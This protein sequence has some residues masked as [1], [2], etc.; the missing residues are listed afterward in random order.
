MMKILI[1]EQENLATDLYYPMLRQMGYKPCLPVTSAMEAFKFLQRTPVDLV[2]L[3]LTVA[4]YRGALDVAAYIHQHELAVPV[5]VLSDQSDTTL[6]HSIKKYHP[7]AFLLKPVSRESLFAVI[8]L[9]APDFEHPQ[10]TEKVQDIFIKTGTRHERINLQQLAFAKANGKYT[11]LHFSF[12]K[13][14][15]RMSLRSFIE[16][17]QNILRLLR[18]H[19]TYAVNP[20]RVSSFSA[21]EV[22]IAGHTIPIG[23]LFMPDVT[24]SL[25]TMTLPDG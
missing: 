7:A 24:N 4:N 17:Y 23:R 21:Y 19:K 15:V 16:K 22:R 6:I 10:N 25:R 12:G 18:V 2:L 11:E 1:V 5:V 8:E 20:S 9:A 3:N 13:R 14:L